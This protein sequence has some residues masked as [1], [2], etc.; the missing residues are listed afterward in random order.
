[1]ITKEEAVL[2]YRLMLGRDPES[3]DVINN[4]CQNTHSTKALRDLFIKSPEF[5]Q[6]MGEIMV[7]TQAVRHRHP[8]HLPKIPVE[9]EVSAEVLDQMFQRIHKEWDHLGNTEPYWSVVTQPQYYQAEFEA[10]REQFYTSGNHSCQLFLAALRRCGVN[11]SELHTCLEIGC[12]VG[13]ITAYL[14]AVFSQVIANDISG[15]HIALAKQHMDGKGIG[16]V[17]Y[18]QLASLDQLGLLPQVDAIFS[19]ITLQHNP[20]PIMAWMLRTLLNSLRPGGVAYF[21]LPTYRNGYIF[22]VERYLHSTPPKTLEMHYLPQHEVFRLVAETGCQCLEVR[23]DGMVGAED[24]M[25]SNT[26]LVQKCK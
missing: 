26:F 17:T 6:R 19:L 16:N 5:V 23:E 25:L 20:P 21:Q 9:T 22:E 24:Q 2:A 8:F 14:A 12:G 18:Q 13:R 10:H 4:V 11:P 3:D 15:P 7:T 1:V